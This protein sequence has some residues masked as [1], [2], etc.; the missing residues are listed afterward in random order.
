MSL[1]T[2]QSNRVF[3][4]RNA[5][6]IT[7]KASS[8]TAKMNSAATPAAS[9]EQAIGTEKTVTGEETRNYVNNLSDK[10]DK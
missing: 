1:P 9:T 5:E 10:F 4:F 2:M 8:I 7:K 6:D 3:I